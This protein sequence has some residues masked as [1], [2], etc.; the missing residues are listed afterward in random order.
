M[1]SNCT[2]PRNNM[3]YSTFASSAW[4]VLTHGGSAMDALVEG[5]TLCEK[6]QCDG[7]VGYGGSPD[8]NGETTLDA[9]LMDGYVHSNF[10]IIYWFY[11]STAMDVGAVACLRRVKDAIKVARAVL[12][13]S[14]HTLLVGEL[15]ELLQ[16]YFLLVI[17]LC[18]IGSYKFCCFYGI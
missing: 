7:T 5:C 17:N 3:L 10:I 4:Q 13:H 6:D 1:C 9:M 18:F 11:C 8:E 15:G 12:Q 16:F 14:R 2:A